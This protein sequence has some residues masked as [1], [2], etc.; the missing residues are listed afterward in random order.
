MQYRLLRNNKESGPYTKAQLE[1]M[2][3]KPYDLLWIEGRGGAWLYASEIDELKSIAPTVEEQPFDRFYKG[4]EKQATSHKQ[5]ASPVVNTTAVSNKTTLKA[6]KP[7]FRISGDKVVMIDDTTLQQEP[8]QAVTTAA[9]SSKMQQQPATVATKPAMK[10]EIGAHIQSVGMDWEEMYSDWKGNDREADVEA[11][12]VKG[13]TPEEVK[14]RYEE[15]KLK[16]LGEKQNKTTSNT[17]QNI[18]AAVAV[19]VLAIGGYAGYKLNSNSTSHERSTQTAPVEKAEVVQDENNQQQ[20][21][22]NASDAAVTSATQQTPEN[23]GATKPD[24]IKNSLSAT[25]SQNATP[26]PPPESKAAASEPKKDQAVAPA[27][28]TTANNAEKPNQKGTLPVAVPEKNKAVTTGSDNAVLTAKDKKQVS[29]QPDMK[30]EGVTAPVQNIPATQPSA[31][32]KQEPPAKKISDYVTINKLGN[33]NINS[34]QN[35]LLSVKNVTDFPI[36]LAVIDIQ[37]YG[38][39]GH[40]Q[41]GETMYVKNIGA[42]NNVNVRVPDSKTSR[43]ITYKISL[44]SS[45]QK[46][47]YLV[48]E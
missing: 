26:V 42:G 46:T 24:E 2:G 9:S 21:T 20:N 18:M 12:P 31:V 34:V 43:S 6:P 17:R 27:K 41:K 11:A 32:I 39:N 38:S 33:T 37:Y 35:I 47:L 16:Q 1:E 40:F 5:N 7:R 28:N 36:D 23:T 22:A 48:G 45:E 14:H 19:L 3:L 8:Q 44:V 15:T 13:Q 4:R 10:Q 30:K 25:N 29:V